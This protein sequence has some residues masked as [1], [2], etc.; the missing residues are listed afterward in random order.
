MPISLKN[1]LADHVLTEAEA[2]EVLE[3][4]VGDNVDAIVSELQKAVV[5][6]GSGAL[7]LKSSDKQVTLNRFLTRLD[8]LKA[9]PVDHAKAKKAD[10]SMDWFSVLRAQLTGSAVGEVM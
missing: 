4:E 8:G 9:I 10:G 5:A 6:T 3:A 7:D 2:S 1:A